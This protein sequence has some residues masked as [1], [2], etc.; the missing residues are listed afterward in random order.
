MALRKLAGRSLRPIQAWWNHR[1]LPVAALAE[2]QRD[3]LGLPKQDPGCALV[4]DQGIEWLSRA[5]D[6]SASHD[7]GIARD[8]SL[9]RGW[10]PSYPETTGYIIPTILECANRRGDAHLHLRAR[11]MLDWLLSIQLP[12]GGFQGGVIGSTPV[13]PVTFNTGQIIIGLARGAAEFGAPYVEPLRRAADWLVETQDA[14]G[15]WRK[16]PTPF[17]EVGEKT[18]E[19]HVSWG[20]IEAARIEPRRGYAEAAL[21]NARWALQYQQP[22][23][24]FD[25]CC[26]SDPTKPLTHTL[27]Y[28]LRGLIEIYRLTREPFLLDAA[29]RTADGLRSAMCVDGYIPGRLDRHW[30]AATNSCCLTGNVQIA[31]CWMLLYLETEDPQYLSAAQTANA[32]VRRTIR[33]TGDPDT[34]GA[35][36]GSFP[37]NGSYGTYQYLNWA[38]KFAIDANLLEL[39]LLTQARKVVTQAA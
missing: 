29:M 7:G 2:Y 24:W 28:V 18:Y 22:N 3:E 23:G 1:Q 17:A 9:I 33:V 6:Q 25:R 16:H 20:L 26:L 14:D 11:R 27:G 39:D 34:C 13:V 21:A 30:Q 5:Q 15:C 8:Y 10:A 38:C 35:V 19:T 31:A 32:F 12:C 4:I 37:V 36:K